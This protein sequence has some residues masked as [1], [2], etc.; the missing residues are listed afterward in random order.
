MTRPRDAGNTTPVEI[1]APLVGRLMVGVFVLGAKSRGVQLHALQRPTPPIRRRVVERRDVDATHRVPH[2]LV[3]RAV[4]RHGIRGR[5]EDHGIV[6]VG[7]VPEGLAGRGR[8]FEAMRPGRD[9]PVSK[10]RHHDIDDIARV[11][12]ARIDDHHVGTGN[13]VETQ[14]QIHRSPRA[15]GGDPPPVQPGAVVTGTAPKHCREHVCIPARLEDADETPTDRRRRDPRPDLGL[16]LQTARTPTMELE[17]RHVS[18][19]HE[20]AKRDRATG[21]GEE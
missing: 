3:K 21:I 8:Q 17:R 12:G 19:D 4:I 15:G 10:S 7:D 20:S 6:V 2:V 11:L 1:D 13:A 16:V 18:N 5:D 9:P 14:P